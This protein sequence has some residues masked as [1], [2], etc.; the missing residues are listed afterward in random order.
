[1][2]TE[3]QPQ[4]VTSMFRL[5]YFFSESILAPENYSHK[6][7]SRIDFSSKI[8]YRR[9][10]KHALQWFTAFTNHNYPFSYQPEENFIEKKRFNDHCTCNKRRNPQHPPEYIH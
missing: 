9:I 1:M 3:R 5:P 7:L 2:C 10:S 6:L 8:N 4:Q